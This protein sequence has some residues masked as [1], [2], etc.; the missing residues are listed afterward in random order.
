M[1][2]N[3]S[4]S[5]QQ[6]RA[7]VQRLLSAHLDPDAIRRILLDTAGPTTP[8]P[9]PGQ[10][11]LSPDWYGH[12]DRGLRKNPLDAL[13][14]LDSWTKEE[15]TEQ[16][17]ALL[18]DAFL[19][20]L[21][22]GFRNSRHAA[23]MTLNCLMLLDDV[24]TPL[25]QRFVNGLVHARMRRLDRDEDPA[26]PLTAVA[27]S[28]GELLAS[29]PRQEL[30]EYTGPDSELDPPTWW[31]RYV[32]GDL[33]EHETAR[34]VA[35][36]P[37]IR[38]GDRALIGHNQLTAMVY[39]LTGGHPASTALLVDAMREHPLEH[40]DTLTRLLDLPEPRREPDRPPL[41]EAL[42]QRLLGEF[43]G[44]TQDLVTFAA[45]HTEHHT[46]LLARGDLLTG[47]VDSYREI[48]PVLWPATGGAGATVLRR[49][50]LRE[51][52]ARADDE[53]AS[54]T[55]VNDW[56][57][58]RCAEE[59]D[60]EGVLHYAMAGGD[61]ATV[62][63]ALRRRL[64]DDPAGWVRLLR[65]V[66]S[67]PRRPADP[68][69]SPMDQL[70]ATLDERSSPLTRLVAGLWIASDPFISNQRMPLYRQIAADYDLVARLAEVNPE[71]L[72]EAADH[73]RRLADLWS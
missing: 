5:R 18:W 60:A 12:Q 33:S 46:G 69:L 35:M 43:T 49:L 45:A 41:G 10:P 61:I 13:V 37:P 16:V 54:W 62:G 1:R 51:L 58:T 70:L 40:G 55:K 15:H 42:R 6:A 30:V 66:T 26:D 47:G 59:G 39:G 44:H 53:P 68:R 2:T 11:T 56:L 48:A 14:E 24:D 38:A 72:L 31:C 7:E 50:L 64:A 57:R 29:V 34:L 8:L 23:E 9:T 20:D 3:L 52:D 71:P 21:R 4:D 36:L 22:D 19:A 73:E 32:L 25:G 17:D 27:T 28:R 65:S 67:M 63:E